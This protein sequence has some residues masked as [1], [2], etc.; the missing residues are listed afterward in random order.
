MVFF[1]IR[2][3]RK[4]DLP[5]IKHLNILALSS[6]GGFIPNPALDQDLENITK[7]YLDDSGEF[8]VAVYRKKIIGMGAVKKISKKV[9]ELKRM[10]IHPDFWRKGFGS[11]L[12]MALEKRAAEQHYQKIVLDTM[13]YQKAAQAFYQKHGY[14]KIKRTIKKGHDIVLYFKLLH[15]STAT[16]NQ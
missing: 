14:K 1:T 16:K 8:Y 5:A 9:V 4:S 13:V 11:A 12:L 10:R 15:K 2:R 3:Y 6:A 7:N